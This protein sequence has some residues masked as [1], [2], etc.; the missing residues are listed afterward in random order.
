LETRVSEL[1]GDISTLQATV[2]KKDAEAAAA[3]AEQ[4][5][6][7]SSGAAQQESEE[8]KD[9]ILEWQNR[10][11][12]AVQ[13]HGQCI[14]ELE[15]TRESNRVLERENVDLQ[16]R[17][18]E[19]EKELECRTAKLTAEVQAPGHDKQDADQQAPPLQLPAKGNEQF[20]MGT[21]KAGGLA[22]LKLKELQAERSRLERDSIALR[23]EVAD[24]KLRLRSEAGREQHVATKLGRFQLLEDE[25][26]RLAAEIDSMTKQMKETQNNILAQ[27]SEMEPLSRDVGIL[28]RREKMWNSEK[29]ELETK[30][31]REKKRNSGTHDPAEEAKELD[32]AKAS[33]EQLTKQN[34]QLEAVKQLHQKR[35]EEMKRVI[36]ALEAERNADDDKAKRQRLAATTTGGLDSKPAAVA[37]A[38]AGTEPFKG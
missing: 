16:Q 21:E 24:L 33:V 13:D 1:Q 5:K 20:L 31:E 25:N 23:A 34:K 22:H 19:L 29:V 2:Q 4:E 11:R 18:Q 27:K 6:A 12:Q 32:S 8:V 38:P 26:R 14:A 37:A 15:R 28:R 10:H 30:L 7:K 9:G 36:S 17:T 3:R 35:M